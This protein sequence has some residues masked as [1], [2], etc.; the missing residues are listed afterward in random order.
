ML[1]F[2]SV[3]SDTYMTSQHEANQST[4]PGVCQQGGDLHL[5]TRVT[6]TLG[7]VVQPASRHDG[8]ET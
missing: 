2:W 7:R 4:D 6:V 3:S 5:S 1:L 8:I